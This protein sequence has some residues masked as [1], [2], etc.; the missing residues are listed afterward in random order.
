MVRYISFFLY[1]LRGG[2]IPRVMTNLANEFAERGLDVDFV[3]GEAAG[4]Y[5]SN[6]SQ[7]VNV[8]ELGAS[9]ALRCIRGL[10]CYLTREQPEILLSANTHLNLVALLA[11]KYSRVSTRLVITEHAEYY[12]AQ[13]NRRRKYHIL[14]QIIPFLIALEYP[15]ADQV[16]GVSES[17]TDS[18]IDRFKF[19][20]DLLS[21]IWNPVIS[22]EFQNMVNQPVSHPWFEDKE[23][24]IVV[25]IGRKKKKKNYPLLLESI[26]EVKKNLPI[27]LLILG[28]GEDR[29]MLEALRKRLNLTEEVQFLGFVENP[30]PYLKHA[31]LFV[32]TSLWEGLPTVLIEALAVGTPVV[33]TDSPGGSREIIEMAGTGRLVPVDDRKAL[34][35]SILEELTEDDTEEIETALAP[36]TTTSSADLYL[37]LFNNLCRGE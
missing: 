24:H 5:L 28:E 21:T 17:V 31:D 8:V 13:K 34:V 10:S 15:W 32:L 14:S 20:G 27:R 25:S 33:V 26:A 29:V 9:R 3:L 4:P 18:L 36:F 35:Q 7:K 19:R 22:E 11:H 37:E 6:L 1:S 2:G 16:V 23:T 30:F 12:Q